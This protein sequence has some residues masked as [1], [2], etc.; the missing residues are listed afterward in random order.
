MRLLSGLM[1][2][3]ISKGK[4]T[5]IDADGRPHVFAGT[6]PGPEITVRLHDRALYAKLFLNPELYAGEAYMDGTLTIEGGASCL[7]FLNLF[8]LNRANMRKHPVQKL[9]KKG[10]K[11]LQSL[12][13]FNTIEK[14]A[15]NV[16]HHYDLSTD[17]YRLFLDERMQYT[18]AYY[19]SP[20]D[21]LE[22]AQLNKLA[23]IAAKLDLKDGMRIAELGCGWGGLSIYLAQIADIHIT[24]V[25]LSVEQL[26]YAR[27]K[28]RELGLED[29]IDFLE[30]DYRQLEGRFDRVVSI[31]MLEHVG[32]GFYDVFFAKLKSL[33]NPDGW[34]LIHSIGR[35]TPPGTTSAF[36]RK[37]IFP[38]GT[39][40]ALS[41]VMTSTEKNR[42]WVNDVE[43]WRLH[44]YYTL[45]HWL[46]RF[47]AN[48]DKAAA[49]YDERFCRMWEFYLAACAVG[50]TGGSNQVF[51]VIVSRKRDAVPLLR[52][53]MVDNERI[54]LTRDFKA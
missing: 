33:L 26:A 17:M 44:Y 19:T 14:S 28:A 27:Q 23:H 37:Y 45:L 53:F 29:R 38:G 39:I 54:L 46:E 40:P 7:E 49:I 5:I 3:F 1:R 41:D 25:N 32:R 16:A 15:R 34:A 52:D 6:E 9:V 50:F 30:M 20:D 11:K 8:M 13:R 12:F 35:Y 51:H 24:A 10:R 2:Q 42:L 22:Q 48:W 47:M 31:G 43:V 18:C 4:L 21:T 36:L